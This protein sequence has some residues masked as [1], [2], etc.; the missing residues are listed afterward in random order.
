LKTDPRRDHVD[1]YAT[2]QGI[3]YPVHVTFA[4]EIGEG[5]FEVIVPKE[6]TSIR[7]IAVVP[8]GVGKYHFLDLDPK[9][10]EEHKI[11]KTGSYALEFE[12]AGPRYTTSG[13]V[14]PR[15]KSFGDLT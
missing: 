4:R 10:I 5:V 3:V 6:F 1:F 9:M 15:I 2:F 7:N 11:R 8:A 12:S 14:W 13:Q